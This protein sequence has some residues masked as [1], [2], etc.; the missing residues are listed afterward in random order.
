MANLSQKATNGKLSFVKYVTENK[1][2]S[3]IEFEIEKGKSSVL[4]TKKRNAAVAGKKEYKA[5]TKLKIVD[6]NLHDVGGMQMTKVKIGNESG[7][8]PIKVIRKPTGGNGTQYEDEVV[9]AI[10]NFIKEAGRPINIKIKGDNKTYKDILYAIK[11]DNKIKRD[12]G[13]KGDPKADIILCKDKDNPL[14]SDSIY[15]S[16]KKEGGPE[17]FQQYGGLSKQA[18]EEIYDHP[19]TQRFLQIVGQA[20]G[21]K[22]QLPYPILAKFTDTTLA[23]MSIYGPEYGKDFSIQHTQIIGQGK[24]KFEKQRNG[25]LYQMSFTSHM[26]LSG[27]LSHFIGGYLPVFGATFR[28]GRGF[29]YKGKRYNGARVAIYPYKL[30]ATR[31]GLKTFEL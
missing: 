12:A 4:F 14:T 7:Y 2:F 21:N 19:T 10:N 22:S 8:L 31:S 18:G 16:H 13:V 20:I 23:N 9:D 1:N 3:A 27:N 11:V 25:E 5:G 26:S 17:A 30:M 15:I 29:E 24:V 6:E 28:A